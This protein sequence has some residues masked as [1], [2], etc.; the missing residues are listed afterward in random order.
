MALIDP[1]TLGVLTGGDGV[2]LTETE[3][4][5][6]QEM[7][8]YLNARYDV[9]AIFSATGTD[10]N[11]LV[12]MYLCDLLLYHLHARVS[13]DHI[14]ELRKERYQNS[15]DWLEKAADGFTSPLLPG[16]DIETGDKP[17]IRYGSSLPK[18]NFHY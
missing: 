12:V 1:H 5:A 10:R 6:M 9:E 15:R 7:A 4:R 11:A 3:G 17:P 8:A 13:P 18:Q 2:L 16:K 14:P